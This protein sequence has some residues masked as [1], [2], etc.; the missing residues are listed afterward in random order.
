MWRVLGVRSRGAP[1]TGCWSF[2]QQLTPPGYRCWRDT[3]GNLLVATDGAVERFGHDVR[4][5]RPNI[6][7]TGVAASDEA[8]WPGQALQIGDVLIGID[9]LRARCIV[10]TIDPDSGS[11]DLDV[12]RGIRRDF[13]GELALNCWVVRPGTIKV[14]DEA[15]LVA[16]D[17][18]PDN[19]GGWIVGAPYPH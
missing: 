18:K 13:G 4:R 19:V 9:S 8:T 6:L 15:R 14:G 7:I 16:L 17:A 5:L 11:Q 1:G 10:T 2:L 3:G 12:L